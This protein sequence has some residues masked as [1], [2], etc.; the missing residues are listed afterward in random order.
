[1]QDIIKQHLDVYKIRTGDQ[2]LTLDYRW[3]D[4][5]YHKQQIKL[6]N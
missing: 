4:T 2:E 3:S 1:M 6:L 5:D